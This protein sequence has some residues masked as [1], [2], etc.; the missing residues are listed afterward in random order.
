M[1]TWS[2]AEKKRTMQR[3]S[4]VGVLLFILILDL[5]GF[6]LIF[7]LVP[8]LLT[9]YVHSSHHAIDAY[10]PGVIDW[11]LQFAPGIGTTE[12]R[13]II[14]LG[15]ILASLYALLQFFLAPFWGRLS[16][17]IGRRPVLLMTS[18]GL[19]M[20]YL[21][22]GFS[23]TFTLFLASRILAGIMAGNMGVATAAM[24]DLSTEEG[25][26]RSMGLVGAA[27]GVGFI[28]GPALGG[29]LSTYDMSTVPGSFHPFSAAA[30]VS[31]A[32]SLLS[33][34]L[35][36]FFLTETLPAE[37]RSKQPFRVDYPFRVLSELKEP[38]F[39][40]MM[41][42]NFAFMFLFTSFEFTVT[43]FYKIDF[44]LAPAKIG[45]VFFYMG[46]LLAFGQG[47][48]VRRLSG[49]ISDRA[50]ILAGVL[51]I[52]SGLPL[53]ALSAPSVK[54][55]L[56]ALAPVAIGSS[57]LQPAMAGLA[58]RSISADR[59]GL[60]MG[61][62]RSMGSL[63]RG[64]GPIF[65]SYVYGSMGI[66]V[67]YVMIGVLLLVSFVAGAGTLRSAQKAASNT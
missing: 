11:L 64:V 40:R 60:A 58:S 39:R 46:L 5:M 54:Y 31:V 35:N 17:R 41:A 61:S 38:V 32:L 14:L 6:T 45:L 53:L 33:A 47:Y 26:T 52:A 9:F 56:L 55:S 57:L 44:G 30:F 36:Y 28:V 48:L 21:I 12:E 42:L 51:L 62:F 18:L 8:D 24:A 10:L 4:S 63:A 13:E 1:L 34:L 59:Q 7:P 67:T 66:T 49:R 50:M 27:F 3:R 19:G 23:T 29:L 65:G 25:R 2:Q 16:D 20:A 22:W 15:G 43:F 37:M